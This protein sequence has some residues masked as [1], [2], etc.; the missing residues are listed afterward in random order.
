MIN[1]DDQAD[2]NDCVVCRV[3]SQEP[4]QVILEC[5]GQ[6]ETVRPVEDQGHQEPAENIKTEHSP[7]T[8]N[9][10]WRQ[11]KQRHHDGEYVTINSKHENKPV[12]EYYKRD[13]TGLTEIS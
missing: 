12:S 1:D 8:D 9:P 6:V 13:T 4:V 2:N 7:H 11:V 3:Y 10:D 5:P